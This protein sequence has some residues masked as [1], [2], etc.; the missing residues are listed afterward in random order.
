MTSSTARGRRDVL[1]ATLALAVGG[2]SLSFASGAQA[3]TPLNG[4]DFGR[5]LKNACGPSGEH[6]RLIEETA[7]ALG[8]PVGDPLVQAALQRAICPICGC[9]LAM[10]PA[11]G[12]APSF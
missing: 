1:R 9:P 5:I 8:R 10:A 11:A 2:A 12:G 4:D 7:T 3:L 6:A